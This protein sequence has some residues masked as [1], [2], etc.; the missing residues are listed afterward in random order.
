MII[1][2]NTLTEIF[3]FSDIG[4]ICGDRCLKR[5]EK[6]LKPYCEM[7]GLEFESA[8]CQRRA[9]TTYHGESKNICQCGQDTLSILDLNKS[10]SYC[11]NHDWPCEDQGNKIVCQNGTITNLNRKC[12]NECIT[13]R[14]VSAM[15]LETK[16]ACDKK[17]TMCYNNKNSAYTINEVCGDDKISESAFAEKFCGFSDRSTPCFNNITNGSYKNIRQ[18]Y[19]IG[20]T[21]YVK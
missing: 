8:K 16:E 21:G 7:L 3:A 19:H 17:N 20:F 11:C 15:A 4:L 14:T 12:G 2:S 6:D 1:F 9:A 10:K 5:G 18:C 13:A